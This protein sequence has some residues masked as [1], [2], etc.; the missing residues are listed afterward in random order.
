MSIFSNTP[1]YESVED[2]EEVYESYEIEPTAEAGHEIALEAYETITRLTAGLYIADAMTE[3]AVFEGAQT[4][5]DAES[6]MEASVKE[7][8]E[9]VKQ[10]FIKLRDKIVSW[11]KSVK[12]RV[13]VMF[14]KTGKFVEKY[15]KQIKDK[16]A[17]ADFYYKGY[18][19][20]KSPAA[21]QTS[22]ISTLAKIADEVESASNKPA[23]GKKAIEGIKDKYSDELNTSKMKEELTKDCRGESKEKDL[24]I[25]AGEVDKMIS[26]VKGYNADTKAMKDNV[27]NSVRAIN[28]IIKNIDKDAKG[29]KD[30]SAFTAKTALLKQITAQMQAANSH[31][32]KL[33]SDLYKNYGAVLRRLYGAVKES[34][35]STEDSGD[36]LL[37]AAMKMF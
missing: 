1:L 8:A 18:Q 36:S 5:E 34:A 19:Y 14:M 7:M 11:F 13:L 35:I 31:C 3:N 4:A 23:A 20:T 27:D 33:M 37:E 30:A 25:S 2:I 24:R 32:L 6:V 9:K 29:A 16:A 15:E 26:F 28:K 21:G 12:E 10:A 17:K 22:V